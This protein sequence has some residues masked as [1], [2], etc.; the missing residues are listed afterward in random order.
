MTK[1]T[2]TSIEDKLEQVIKDV[3]KKVDK[4][5]LVLELQAIR[6]DVAAVKENISTLNGYGKWLILLIM[7]AIVTAMLKLV[8]VS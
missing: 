1:P 2:L 7:G 4:D 5:I 6:T 3:D 8:L